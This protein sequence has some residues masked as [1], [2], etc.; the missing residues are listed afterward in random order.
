MDVVKVLLL[1]APAAATMATKQGQTA[2]HAAVFFGHAGPVE[3]LLASDANPVAQ[4]NENWTPL[5]Y[6]TQQARHRPGLA[7]GTQSASTCIAPVHELCRM[8]A[9]CSEHF[10]K[11]LHFHLISVVA[12]H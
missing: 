4:D 5:H 8:R 12:V 1:V 10:S 6:A 7:G 11:P 9:C 3:A 2:L